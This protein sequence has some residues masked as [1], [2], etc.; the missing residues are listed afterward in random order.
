MR[1]WM[2][3]WIPA[4]AMLAG[5]V[6]WAAPA[7]VRV[8]AEG[9]RSGIVKPARRIAR[10]ETEWRAL[11][12]AHYPRGTNMPRVDWAREMVVAVFLGERPTGGYR[13]AVREAREAGGKLRLTVVE[14]KPPPEALTTQAFTSPFQ[15]VA[16]KKSRLPVEWKVAGPAR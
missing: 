1:K 7:S 8:L 12:I 11:W 4:A 15:I 10:T 3:A 2:R 6:T 13:I 16:V 14:S 9:S 5:G